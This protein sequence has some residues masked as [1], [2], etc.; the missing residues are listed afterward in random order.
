MPGFRQKNV[1][2]KSVLDRDRFRG[3]V[4]DDCYLDVTEN[5]TSLPTAT[6]VARTI[7]DQIRQ[8][9]SLTASAERSS[10]ELRFASFRARL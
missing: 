7:R 6:L 1:L 5:K 2:L 4:R 8:E 3:A 9:L 10:T